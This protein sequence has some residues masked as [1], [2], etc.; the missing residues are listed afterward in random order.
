MRFVGTRSLAIQNDSILAWR[1]ELSCLKIKSQLIPIVRGKA[2]S[3]RSHPVSRRSELRYLKRGV[4][5]R[6]PSVVDESGRQRGAAAR[7]V[8]KRLVEP[9]KADCEAHRVFRA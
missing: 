6:C 9:P 8:D 7:G 5:R 2:G 1:Q 3:Y 4:S